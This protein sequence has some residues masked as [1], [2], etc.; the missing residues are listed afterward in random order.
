MCV[1]L[2]HLSA[3]TPVCDYW[4][5]GKNI[6]PLHDLVWKELQIAFLVNAG[7]DAKSPYSS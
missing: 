4:R 6:C 5:P 3:V 7:I 1:D 2:A